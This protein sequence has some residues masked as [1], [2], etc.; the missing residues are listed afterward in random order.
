LDNIRERGEMMKQIK[1]KYNFRFTS[2]GEKISVAVTTYTYTRE[3]SSQIWAFDYVTIVSIPPRL[4]QQ[5]FD[6]YSNMRGVG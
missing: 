6:I 4:T 5:E 3:D 2:D 1:I